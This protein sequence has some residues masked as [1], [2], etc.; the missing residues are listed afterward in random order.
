MRSFDG[1]DRSTFDAITCFFSFVFLV[2]SASET[3]S[4]AL[5]DKKFSSFSRR[6]SEIRIRDANQP[7][8]TKTKIPMQTLMASPSSAATK[9]TA[10]EA[11]ERAV[12]ARA[13]VLRGNGEWISASGLAQRKAYL[14]AKVRLQKERWCR[15]LFLFHNLE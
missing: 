4:R 7:K 6:N 10:A 8:T 15:I 12:L 14:A 2:P 5:T 11:R 9:A 13:A 3:L 1:V